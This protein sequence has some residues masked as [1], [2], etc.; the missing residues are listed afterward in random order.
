MEAALLLSPPR[1]AGAERGAAAAAAAGR[2]G[3]RRARG[4][5]ARP[6]RACGR[7]WDCAPRCRALVCVRQRA[8]RSGALGAGGECGR[9]APRAARAP[10]QGYR[11]RF[12]GTGSQTLGSPGC[13]RPRVPGPAPPRALGGAPRRGQMTLPASLRRGPGP[14]TRPRSPGL[15]RAAPPTPGRWG[16]GGAARTSRP[17]PCPAPFA[18]LCQPPLGT[19]QR[20]ACPPGRRVC[21]ARL[22]GAGAH[23]RGFRGRATAGRLIHYGP[24]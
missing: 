9:A 10:G 1:P 12:R 15:G 11:L 8:E 5:S 18:E 17:Q 4:P 3:A 24:E 13:P 21:P 7:G 19:L 23:G 2:L 14:A 16:L 20:P 22:R 6:G